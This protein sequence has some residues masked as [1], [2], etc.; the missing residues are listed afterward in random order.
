MSPIGFAFFSS[1]DTS[2]TPVLEAIEQPLV[3]PQ[4]PTSLAGDYILQDSG[5]ILEIKDNKFSFTGVC[6]SH[7]FSYQAYPTSPS[8]HGSPI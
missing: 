5:V 8:Q 2:L 3:E 7:T 4:V 1:D 6:N